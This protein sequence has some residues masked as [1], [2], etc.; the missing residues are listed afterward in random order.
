MPPQKNGALIFPTDYPKPLAE[1]YSSSDQKMIKKILNIILIAII[2]WVAGLLTT[3]ALGFIWLH[4][5]P[6]VDRV[7]P[8]AGILGEISYLIQFVIYVIW[9]ISPVAI[10]G[11]II[12]GLIPREGTRKDQLVYAAII[13]GALTTPVALFFLWY[14]GF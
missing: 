3:F 14:T 12:G 8:G 1:S 4:V 13:S 11:G 5:F 2:G 6:V 10:I 7:I 9:I